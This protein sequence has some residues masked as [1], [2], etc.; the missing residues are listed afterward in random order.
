VACEKKHDWQRDEFY[1]EWEAGQYVDIEV[2][3]AVAETW[4]QKQQAAMYYSQ[5]VP[6]EAE[7]AQAHLSAAQLEA[8]Q[9]GAKTFAFVAA[10]A[11]AGGGYYY[12]QKQRKKK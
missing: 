7:I 12:Y 6:Y 5:A 4:Y 11:L 3:E 10:V 9:S 1:K 2:E 8:S